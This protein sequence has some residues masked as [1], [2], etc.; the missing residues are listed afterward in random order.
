MSV[1]IVVSGAP[2]GTESTYNALR[3]AMSL[4][5]QSET[6]ELR[7]FLLGDAVACA[8]PAQRTPSGYYNVERM[9]RHILSGGAEVRACLTCLEARGL[10]AIELIEG[11]EPSNVDELAAWVSESDKVMAF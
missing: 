9:L 7:V 4:R 11:I 8:V 2:Y 3:L 5:R 1:L 10:T 6:T